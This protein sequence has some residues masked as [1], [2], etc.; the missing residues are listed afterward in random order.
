MRILTT[1]STLSGSSLSTSFFRRRSKNG[2]RTLCSRRMMSSA[3]SSLSSILSP[4]PELANGVLNHSSNDLTELKMRGSTKLSCA[5][6]S[7][8]LFCSGVPVRISR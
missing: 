8:R 4:V 5:Q 3:S 6:S 2:R 1:F 7:G